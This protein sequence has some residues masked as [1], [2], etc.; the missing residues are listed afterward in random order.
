MLGSS[1]DTSNILSALK[2]YEKDGTHGYQSSYSVSTVRTSV[3][4]ASDES[5]LGE[6][7]FYDEEGNP[8][9]E[10]V[11][12]INGVEFKID[13]QTTLN[14]LISNING[15]S[16]TNVKASYDALNNQ[17]ILT[18][19]QTGQNNISLSSK[20]TNLLNVLGLTEGEGDNEVLAKGS[21]TL[22]QN[23]IAYINGNKVISSSNTITGESSGIAN[24]SITIKKPTSDYSNNTEDDKNVTLDIDPD[25]SKVKEA[26]K[27]FVNA[28]NEV[29]TTTRTMTASDGK[30][31]N[32]ATLNSIVSTI[33]TM[34]TGVGQNDGAFNML[35]QIGIS[36]SKT[37]TTKL[38]I[39][40]SKLDEA[41]SENFESVKKLLSDG[42]VNKEDSGLFD[43]LLT[44]VSNVLNSTN[45]YFANA[46]DSVESQIKNMN[47][48]IERATTRLNKYEIRITNQFN[49]MDST[50]SALNGQLST[51]AS[52]FG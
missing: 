42:Y 14:E 38:T 34:T 13:E 26:L 3:A 33:R 49:K 12:S 9:T 21:Q 2:L 28:Y 6:I 8:A 17:L 46:A 30:I 23:A 36:T 29:V 19:T 44:Q 1:A 51:F 37:D 16:E 10:G 41:L 52:Y 50:I 47:N 39:D 24:L 18:S 40:D 5:G 7:K 32:D 31:G 22:G 43:K 35:S 20:G 27:T 11:I 45:G 15:N 48:R 4:M 25:Y